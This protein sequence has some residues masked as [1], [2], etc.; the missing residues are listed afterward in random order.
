MDADTTTFVAGPRHRCGDRLMWGFDEDPLTAAWDLLH[1]AALPAG[2]PVACQGIDPPDWFIEATGIRATQATDGWRLERIEAPVGEVVLLHRG[3]EDLAPVITDLHA[4][5][6]RIDA[7]QAKRIRA[8]RDEGAREDDF[9][10]GAHVPLARHDEVL[11]ARLRL[12]PGRVIT[13]TTIGAGAAPTEFHRRQEAMGAYH[14]AMVEAD[15]ARTVG[16]WAVKDPP[17]TGQACRPVLRRLLR[18]QGTWR[19]GVAFRPWP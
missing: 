18:Q 15:G 6:E 9:P 7:A 19:Y 12:G 1:A 13:W 8:A 4:E 14:V 11:R 17:A 16:L 5:A 2:T 10:L 3:D